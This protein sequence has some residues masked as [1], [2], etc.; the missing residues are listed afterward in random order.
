ME[1]D[2]PMDA[3]ANEPVSNEVFELHAGALRLVLRPDI[4]GSIASLW[5][6]DLAV[7]RGTEPAR[8]T[9]ARRAGSFPL[10]PYSNRLAY[11][12][13]R[14]KGRDYGTAANFDDSAHSLHGVGWQRAWQV[15]SSSAVDVVLRLRHTPDADWPFAFEAR[16]YFTLTP[17]SMRVQMV[18]DNL[19]ELA[20]PVGLGWHPY[21]P[22]RARSRLHVELASRWDNDASLLPVRQIAQ[23]G[24][25]SDVRHLD[26]DNCFDGWRGAARI[27]DERLSLGLTSSLDRLVV[28]TP[29][30]QDYFCVEPVS[31]V[32]NAIHMADPMAHGLR[33]LA[34]G[35]STD[36]W[37]QLDI[38]V[39]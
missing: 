38:K 23:D 26:Y 25:D 32:S 16:Q 24:I 36:A 15:L 17:D 37:M 13:F 11:R 21:F 35:E 31:H 33:V 4:G 39:L 20:Q 14:W 8:L 22:R 30:D 19:D 12:R 28:Y 2:E 9:S 27:R 29:G 18:V 3:V 34:P 10:V 5:H 6:A 7:L 1:G